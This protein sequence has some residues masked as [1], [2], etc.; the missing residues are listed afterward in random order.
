MNHNFSIG[1][2]NEENVFWF[3]YP[4]KV[5]FSCNGCAICCKNTEYKVRKILL[6]KIEAKKI[7]KKTL[8]DIDNFSEKIEKYEPY[9]YEMKKTKD[10]R[11]VFLRGN[12]CRIYKIRPLICRFYPFKLENLSDNRYRFTYTNE[13]P[14]I[15]KGP[16]LKKAY[17]KKMFRNFIHVFRAT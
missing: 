2:L 12:L 15:G 7:S 9:A 1:I 4:E 5:D 16:P 11:C 6:L 14:S 8:I 13:C 17:F 10:G 3:I